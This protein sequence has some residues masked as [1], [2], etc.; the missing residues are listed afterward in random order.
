MWM[1]RT[2][3]PPGEDEGKLHAGEV[4]FERRADCE[5][6]VEKLKTGRSP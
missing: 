5:K 1:R 3:F 4:V 2:I 6:G